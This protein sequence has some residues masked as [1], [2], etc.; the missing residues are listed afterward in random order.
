MSSG[1]ARRWPRALVVGLCA[2]M[3]GCRSS[4]L[5]EV[6]ACPPDT[7]TTAGWRTVDAGPFALRLPPEY[8]RRLL[9]GIDSY[10]GAWEAS[11]RRV[12]FDFGPFS[13]LRD[14]RA[15]LDTAG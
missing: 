4:G 1:Q 5:D 14:S 9:Q 7:V 3:H 12:S 6:D 10:V 15:L 2:L 13:G 8:E 11:G